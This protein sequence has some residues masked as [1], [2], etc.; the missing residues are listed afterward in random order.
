MF[1]ANVPPPLRAHI[2]HEH[3]VCKHG[4]CSVFPRLCLTK[5]Y[6]TATPL[7]RAVQC[8]SPAVAGTSN[9]THR[10]GFKCENGANSAAAPK[11]R[12]MER[13]DARVPTVGLKISD[14]ARLLVCSGCGFI[15]RIAAESQR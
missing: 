6:E 14:N 7:I 10:N 4:T 1:Y 3:T 11:P 15:F 5:V 12:E 8:T 2:V 9:D 13:F